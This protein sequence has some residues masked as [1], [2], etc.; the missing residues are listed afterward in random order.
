MEGV[1]QKMEID[2]RKKK[3]LLNVLKIDIY[4][5]T[6]GKEKKIPITSNDYP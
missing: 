5:I 1:K 3:K 6:I 2:I 4:I